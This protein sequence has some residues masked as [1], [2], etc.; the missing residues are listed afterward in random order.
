M[1]KEIIESYVGEPII[2]NLI[3]YCGGKW[4]ND[5][6]WGECFRF[7]GA[8]LCHLSCIFI[9]ETDLIITTAFQNKEWDLNKP[10]TDD[11]KEEITRFIQEIRL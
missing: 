2:A 1:H 7:G 11:I 10:L 4:L 6:E 3:E 9:R 8:Y 5:A